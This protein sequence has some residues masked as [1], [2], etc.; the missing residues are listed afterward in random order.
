MKA[1]RALLGLAVTVLAAALVM[2][3]VSLWTDELLGGPIY[4]TR[5]VLILI[6]LAILVYLVPRLGKGTLPHRLW[7]W[8]SIAIT[9]NIIPV[10][11]ET[12]N[13]YAGRNVFSPDLIFLFYLFVFIPVLVVIGVLYF[14]FKKQG[15]EF[16]RKSVLSVLPSMLVFVGVTVVVLIVPMA[17]GGGDLGVKISDIF[18]LVVQIAALCIISFMAITIGRGEA[19]R[20]Y[21]FISLALACIIVQTILTAH[22]R[23]VGI[24]ST[25]EPADFFLHAA[26]ALLIFA[27]YFQYE[28]IAPA[29][30]EG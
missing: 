30:V 15:F 11:L 20:P 17:T 9:I 25:T 22:I 21:L 19:G 8:I 5:L 2:Y 3:V 23:L 28:M 10:T 29:A 14:G 7:L 6:L 16:S 13:A 12:I 4:T 18:A 1:I 26:Y 27:A 24:M